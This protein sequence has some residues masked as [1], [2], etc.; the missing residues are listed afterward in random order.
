M[1][2]LGFVT[3]GKKKGTFPIKRNNSEHENIEIIKLEKRGG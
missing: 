2:G 3:F 1:F